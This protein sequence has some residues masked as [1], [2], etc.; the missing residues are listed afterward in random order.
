MAP[1]LL[2]LSCNVRFEPARGEESDL[3][4][5]RCG[6]ALITAPP[7]TTAPVAGQVR[8][9]PAPDGPLAHIHCPRC[10]KK[11]PP[12]CLFCPFCDKTLLDPPRAALAPPH[13][14]RR[15]PTRILMIVLG[16]GAL[17]VW[18]V[19]ALQQAINWGNVIPAA[20]LG[21]V[22]SVLFVVGLVGC[23]LSERWRDLGVIEVTVRLLA[24]VGVFAAVGCSCLA[25][26]MV[27]L[28]LI[29]VGNRW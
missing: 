1:A 29:C 27:F 16:C 26:G 25:A 8:P 28:L 19:F 3:N 24:V 2:C 22:V 13:W 10:E 18:G 11:V 4:C 20:I 21:L 17:L 12:E 15:Q 9:R 7:W 5:P 23:S 6:T 14:P